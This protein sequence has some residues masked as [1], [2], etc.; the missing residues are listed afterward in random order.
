M[1]EAR[2][3]RARGPQRKRRLQTV[4]PVAAKWAREKPCRHPSLGRQQRTAGAKHTQNFGAA[5]GR[6]SATAGA[7]PI[8]PPP[9]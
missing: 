5:R 6:K 3:P 4:P 8:S 2:R 7:P 1:E 9:S